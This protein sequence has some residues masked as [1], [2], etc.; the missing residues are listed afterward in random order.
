MM[1][2]KC[3]GDSAYMTSAQYEPISRLV[4]PECEYD[5]G[6]SDKDG[7]ILKAPEDEVWSLLHEGIQRI[8]EVRPE[9]ER[10]VITDTEID[11]AVKQMVASV[12]KDR[13]KA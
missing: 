7:F 6:T 4:C 10:V 8:N 11:H 9:A 2:P 13:G 12:L 1:C 5:E 3:G